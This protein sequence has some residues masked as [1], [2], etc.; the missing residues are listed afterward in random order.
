MTSVLPEFEREYTLL[1]EHDLEFLY[2][3][4]SRLVSVIFEPN[5]KYAVIFECKSLFYIILYTPEGESFRGIDPNE[6]LFSLGLI[7]YTVRD[8]CCVELLDLMYQE[9][10]SN[11]FSANYENYVSD[12]MYDEDD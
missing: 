6:K 8:L 3:H 4:M 11:D 7:D 1:H 10:F 5:I 2:S 12:H 9:K